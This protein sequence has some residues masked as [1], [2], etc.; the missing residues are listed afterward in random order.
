MVYQIIYD[1]LNFVKEKKC[2]YVCTAHYEPV[3]GTDGITYS[4]PCRLGVQQCKTKNQD[5]KVDYEG[6]CKGISFYK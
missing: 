5:L 4:N 2:D 6:E 3:C 1:Q